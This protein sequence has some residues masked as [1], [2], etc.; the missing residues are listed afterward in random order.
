MA[1]FKKCMWNRPKEFLDVD[2]PD[3][4]YRLKRALY[5]LKQAPRAWFERLSIFLMRNGY[6]R[7]G[8]DNTLFIKKERDQFMVAQIYV[9]D[10]VFRGVSNQLVKQ[11]VQQ[12]EAE[13]EISIVGELK[14]FLGFQINQIED[15]IFISQAKYAKN[16]VKKFGLETSKSKRTP[17][18]T[19]VKVTKDEDGKSVDISAYRSMI[20]SLLYLSASIRDIPRYVGVCARYQADPKE[21][22]L[23][24]VKRI[25][26]Y[27]QGTFNHGLIALLLDIVLL[28]G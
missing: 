17:F 23:N 8:V 4:V 20:G 16:I 15:S 11:L 12:M 1:L 6:I 21:N 25:L 22:H 14:Y 2:R 19:H 9:D 24:L 3:H 26:K 10:I 7:G 28:T 13:F 18:A 5:G 27:I